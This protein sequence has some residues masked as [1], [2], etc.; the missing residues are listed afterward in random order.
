PVAGANVRAT[1]AL[2]R[3]YEVT[4]DA[5]GVWALEGLSPG[6]YKITVAADGFEPFALTEQVVV[7]EATSVLYRL[8][9]AT[10]ADE[11]IVVAE[12]RP[13]EV[14]RRTLARREVSQVPGTGGDALRAIQSLPGVA[15]PPGLAGALIVRG[16]SPQDTLGFVDGTL[17]PL[18][19]HFGGLS[20][21]IPTEL[22]DKIDFYPGNFGSKY[23]RA[24]AGV[25]DVKLRSPDTE[26]TG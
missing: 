21:V 26:C 19:Y 7:G 3:V 5:E 1:D 10:D 16:S 15:R 24:S 18:I 2:G 14:S 22:L 9:P 6:A 20:S 8:A 17:V 11:I 4:A 12:R 13:R 25:V 23:G